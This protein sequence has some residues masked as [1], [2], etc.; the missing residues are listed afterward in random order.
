[1]SRS[2]N[3]PVSE[4]LRA[5]SL[6]V[7]R[8]APAA[9][10]RPPR[11]VVAQRG[12]G[13]ARRE[14]GQRLGRRT[15]PRGCARH[16]HA[17]QECAAVCWAPA[18]AAAAATLARAGAATVEPRW[19][20]RHRRGRRRRGGRCGGV[21]CVPRRGGGRV[22]LDGAVAVPAC[23]PGPRRRRCRRRHH[24]LRLLLRR[25][26]G[27]M[28]SRGVRSVLDPSLNRPVG[29]RMAAWRTSR[30]VGGDGTD[31]DERLPLPPSAPLSND[32][33]PS[34]YSSSP[35]P[36]AASSSWSLLSLLYRP[37]LLLPLR[38]SGEG[39]SVGRVLVTGER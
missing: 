1:M 14:R 21:R 11:P 6:G 33:P 39:G 8:P 13:A 36:P 17:A 27:R 29:A 20:Q 31:D 28:S 19:L 35:S 38:P 25:A 5:L 2:T 10:R 4:L 18:A 24:G 15:C 12:D 7:A 22:R 30:G 32:P 16:R 9:P 34:S 23:R 26:D 37:P 3:P